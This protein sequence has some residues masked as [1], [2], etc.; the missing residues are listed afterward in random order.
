MAL[1]YA[2]R[3]ASGYAPENTVASFDLALE[4]HADGI[5]TDVRATRDGVLVLLHDAGVDRTT[6]GKGAIAELTFEQ[7]K[8]LDAGSHFSPAHAAQRVP[9]LDDFLDRYAGRTKFWLEIKAAGIE[10]AAV[11]A[12]RQRRLDDDVAFTSFNCGSLE[13]VRQASSAASLTY[14]IRELQPDTIERSRGIGVSQLSIH[15]STLTTDVVRA[16]R[17]RGLD[18]RTWGISD[19]ETLRRMLG[20]G[21]YGLTLNWPD[22]VAEE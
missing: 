8:R 11:D 16:V 3:G 4:M 22:W 2:H 1:I 13:A 21:L 12:V 18:V 19:K 5:E 9:S 10:R 20:L 14:L 6:D 17:D 15:H 7:V